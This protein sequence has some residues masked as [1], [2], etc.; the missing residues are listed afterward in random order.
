VTFD[1]R[2]TPDTMDVIK[3]EGRWAKVMGVSAD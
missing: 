3:R 1:E 2:L